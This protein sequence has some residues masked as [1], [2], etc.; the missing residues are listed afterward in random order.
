MTTSSKKAKQSKVEWKG[1]LRVNLT[2]EQEAHFDE[3]LPLQTIQISDFGILCNNGFKFS[4]SW[5]NFHNGVVGS[6]YANDPKL[7]WSGW[8][9]SAWAESA[10]EAIALLFYKH[11]I[12]CEEDWEHFTDVVERTG[13]KRG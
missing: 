8:T 3:W 6:L 10:E 2:P 12:V 4:L 1:Y 7:S 5:D 11:Y 9:L 13:R